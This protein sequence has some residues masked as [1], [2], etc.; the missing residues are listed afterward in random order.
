MKFF[1]PKLKAAAIHFLVSA[2]VV[3][4]VVAGSLY[5]WYPGLQAYAAGLVTLLSIL[6][7]VD[8]VIGPALTLVVF[9]PGKKSLKFDMSVIAGV[10][11]AALVF[12]I[13]SIYQA[14][15]VYFAFVVDRFETV[16]AADL[17]S[18]SLQAAAPEYQQ[19]F[20]DGPRWIGVELPTDREELEEIT[21]AEAVNGTGPALIP[22]YYRPLPAVLKAGLKRAKPLEELKA[23]NPENLVEEKIA[24]HKAL[25]DEMVYFPLAGRDRDLTVFVNKQSGDI[26]DVVDL[27][28]WKT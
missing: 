14:R 21:L 9:K 28:P 18:S 24:P 26:I 1:L 12:G 7:I 5:F 2:V 17:E 11:I 13:S 20:G 6:V 23:L 15:P 27:R 8:L 22:R 16:A 19:L 3:G 10:Q 25:E 4:L